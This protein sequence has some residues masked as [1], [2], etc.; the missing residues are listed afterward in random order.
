MPSGAGSASQDAEYLLDADVDKQQDGGA[1][2]EVREQ[3]V[4]VLAGYAAVQEPEQRACQE[5]HKQGAEGGVGDHDQDRLIE[6][7]QQHG[8]EGDPDQKSPEEDAFLGEAYLSEK[9]ILFGDATDGPHQVAE[10]VG[11]AVPRPR[12]RAG[13][14]GPETDQ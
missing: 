6:D 5:E 13:G 4:A 9:G 14:C 8:G 10:E 1:E 2:F 12:D 7:E 3:P 11:I